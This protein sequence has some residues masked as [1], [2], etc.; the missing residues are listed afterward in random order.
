MPWYPNAANHNIP[1]GPADPPIT[2]R[3]IVLHTMVGTIQSAENHFRDGSGIEAHFGVAMDGRVWQWRDTAIQADAQAAGNGY[4]ISIET[5][6]KGDPTRP[7]TAQQLLALDALIT[8]LGQVHSIP[9]RLVRATSERGIG[10]HRQFREWNPHAHSCPGDVRLGQLT[11]DLIPAL[12]QTT[13]ED[14]MSQA[15]VEAITKHIDKRVGAV[16]KEGIQGSLSTMVHGKDGEPARNSLDSIAA[17]QA[18][19]EEKVDR[20]LDWLA[21]P[22]TPPSA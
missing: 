5:E 20:I 11:R 10:Y 12:N 9:M 17:K 1:P 6:D 7:W 16:P 15:D 19:L 18:V 21:Q 2:P 8:W 13:Q 22:F 14:A 4:C 3:I